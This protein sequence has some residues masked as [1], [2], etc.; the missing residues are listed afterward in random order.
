MSKIF[1]IIF[2]L[3]AL[4]HLTMQIKSIVNSYMRV[5]LSC[6]LSCLLVGCMTSIDASKYEDITPKL[7]LEKFFSGTVKG[8]GI[9]QNRNG[10]VVQRFTVKIVCTR[11]NNE[12]ILDED[13]F[14]E[15]GDGPKNR[16]WNIEIVDQTNYIGKANDIAT[17][18]KGLATGNTLNWQ[19]E[20][21]LPVDGRSYHVKFNDW[22]W[23]FDDGTLIN[24]SYIR[25]FGIN[26]AEV[27]IFMQKKN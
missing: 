22:M 3:I 16:K 26:F 17:M 12:L 4:P 14:Y 23:I 18:A 21:D 13:F 8:W 2:F 1:N 20:M 5:F 6:A 15:F 10:D 25:K 27:T 19:Y 7:E 24:R 11:E 9:V